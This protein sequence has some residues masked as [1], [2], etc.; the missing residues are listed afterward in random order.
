MIAFFFTI[1]TRKNN[2]DQG[3]QREIVIRESDQGLKKRLLRPL[4]AGVEKGIVMGWMK[5]SYRIPEERL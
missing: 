4:R 2:A 1:P 3:Y 5:L